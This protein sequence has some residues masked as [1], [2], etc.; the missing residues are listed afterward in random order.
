[1]VV[2][3]VVVTATS[4]ASP[5]KS[6]GHSQYTK[7]KLLVAQAP[8][9]KHGHGVGVVEVVVVVVEVVVVVVDVVV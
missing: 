8:P 5:V 3:V 6:G 2:D 1:M 7:P 9:F 4:Q